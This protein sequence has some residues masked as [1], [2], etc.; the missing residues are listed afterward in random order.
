[1]GQV[2]IYL[3]DEHERRL[4]RAA[5]SATAPADVMIPAVVVY[6]FETGIAKSTD[7]SKRR[8]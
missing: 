8:E 3:D 2:T 4:R 1:M 6:Q 7:Q 5:K